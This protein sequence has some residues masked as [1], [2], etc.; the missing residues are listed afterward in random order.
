MSARQRKSGSV[1]KS[2]KKE[3]DAFDIWLKRGLHQLFDD[4]AKEPIPEEL[5]RLLDNSRDE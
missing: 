3:D 1:K 4:V 5:L 2:S